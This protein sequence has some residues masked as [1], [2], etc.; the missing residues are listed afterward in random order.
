MMVTC[1]Q[2]QSRSITKYGHAPS[3]KQRYR[4]RDCNRQFVQNPARPP[5]SP[6]TRHLIDRL[7]L[8][9]LSLAGI[10]RA[11]GVSLRWLQYYSCF[12]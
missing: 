2:C 3:G 9:R 4:C 8:E 1:P 5:I 7:L 6:D 12:S 10:A 11:T